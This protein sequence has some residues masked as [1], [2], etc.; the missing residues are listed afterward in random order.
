MLGGRPHSASGGRLGTRRV[1]DCQWL[2]HPE[3]CV[4]T[5]PQA[6]APS[7]VRRPE[8]IRR[9]KGDQAKSNPTFRA[10]GAGLTAEAG[11]KSRQARKLKARS[12]GKKHRLQRAGHWD[13]LGELQRGVSPKKLSKPYERVHH[14]DKHRLNFNHLRIV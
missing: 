6:N 7:R 10:Q 12:R 11:T 3:W 14:V 1:A 13:Q 9:A 8:P 4:D 5:G 2:K